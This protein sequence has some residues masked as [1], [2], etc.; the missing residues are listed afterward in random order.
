[1]IGPLAGL[2]VK[3]VLFHQ[4]YNNAFEGSIGAAMYRDIFL[5]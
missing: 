2:A 3:G 1:M 5:K 4:G